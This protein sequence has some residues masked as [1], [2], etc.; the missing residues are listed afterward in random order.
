MSARTLRSGRSLVARLVGL[1]LLG[2]AIGS[3]AAPPAGA[4]E[5]FSWD[6]D[7]YHADDGTPV[8]RWTYDAFGNSFR[9]AGCAS[10]PGLTMGGDITS[11]AYI[12]AH[13]EVK[14]RFKFWTRY[15][16]AVAIAK[17]VEPNAPCPTLAAYEN[18]RA[19]FGDNQSVVRALQDS[20]CT[21]PAHSGRL[22][23]KLVVQDRQLRSLSL[24]LNE[25]CRQPKFNKNPDGTYVR[26]PLGYPAFRG[27][28]SY[29]GWHD[30]RIKIDDKTD[31]IQAGK[32]EGEI[33]SWAAPFA[34]F[35]LNAPT[36]VDDFETMGGWAYIDPRDPRPAGTPYAGE[37]YDQYVG[38][39][40]VQTIEAAD[41]FVRFIDAEARALYASNPRAIP[42]PDTNPLGAQR[43]IMSRVRNNPTGALADRVAAR[44]DFYCSSPYV[45]WMSDVLE[46]WSGDLHP[47]SQIAFDYMLRTW[48]DGE[49]NKHIGGRV[50]RV[51]NQP[52][53]AVQ[54]GAITEVPEQQ[55][56]AFFQAA[57][58]CR[59]GTI[60]NIVKTIHV[61][62]PANPNYCM[63]KYPSLQ[64]IGGKTYYYP[65]N[66]YASALFF[67]VNLG[68]GKHRHLATFFG[69]FK[70]LL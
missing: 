25:R 5:W 44:K 52:C 58:F 60:M 61:T 13:T 20:A 43:E 6:D 2:T 70:D 47:A 8:P 53:H 49:I 46:K 14:L 67:D 31:L 33:P 42:N 23:C 66:G 1:V 37:K 26:T 68:C 51:R 35:H 11:T 54:N 55:A 4:G 48:I 56:S 3:M 34:T 40:K 24:D 15:N 39:G 12:D 57:F 16:E 30:Q 18:Y 22:W 65:P 38:M 62:N 36:F 29:T 28:F 7:R 21:K 50:V 59:Y 27:P 64:T 69:L 10:Y 9:M 63:N 41:D 17:S 45:P 32:E 19:R